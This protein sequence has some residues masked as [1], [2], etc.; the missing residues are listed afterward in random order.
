MYLIFSYS[1]HLHDYA[2]R[3]RKYTVHT[4]YVTV[5]LDI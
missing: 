4:L 1:F 2:Y 3:H 5:I